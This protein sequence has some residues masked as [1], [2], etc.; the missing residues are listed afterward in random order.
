MGMYLLDG[1]EYAQYFLLTTYYLVR[2][3]KTNT[4]F[5]NSTSDYLFK[6]QPN[7]H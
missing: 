5:Y 4:I 6:F 3:R 2:L 7:S 1:A